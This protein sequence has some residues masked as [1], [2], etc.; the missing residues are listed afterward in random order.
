MYVCLRE[1]IERVT[2][3]V[4]DA[5]AIAVKCVLQCAL[6]IMSNNFSI[7][8]IIETTNPITVLRIL[9]HR[10]V[11]TR[12]GAIHGGARYHLCCRR[13]RMDYLPDH[14]VGHGRRQRAGESL[15][16]RHAAERR[17]QAARQPL[18]S[19][20]RRAIATVADAAHPGIRLN[21]TKQTPLRVD[22][23]KIWTMCVCLD[24]QTVKPVD[25]QGRSRKR[26]VADGATRIFS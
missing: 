3:D 10:A 7:Q 9:H 18:Q 14:Y 12:R 23:V 17:D 25:A 19:I 2:A 13:I 11:A 24:K 4:C 20:R 1:R 8:P 5:K 22:V 6:S 26:I 21:K 15:A 16:G